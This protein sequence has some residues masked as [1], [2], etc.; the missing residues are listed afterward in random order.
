M[1]KCTA[2]FAHIT[3]LHVRGLGKACHPFVVIIQASCSLVQDLRMCLGDNTK[4][5]FNHHTENMPNHH[6]EDVFKHT[7]R[8]ASP[9]GNSHSGG[10]AGNGYLQH[11][12]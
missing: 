2:I 1:H 9:E 7:Y 12:L 6:T 11:L 4:E 8:E 3:M 10:V 5:V